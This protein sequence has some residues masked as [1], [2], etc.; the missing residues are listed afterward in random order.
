MPTVWSGRARL[1]RERRY[2][3]ELA[4]CRG[5][6]FVDEGSGVGCC[7]AANP[8]PVMVVV[9]L[10][11]DHESRP[12]LLVRASS[13]ACTSSELAEKHPANWAN[14]LG[15]TTWLLKLSSSEHQEAVCPAV[16]ANVDRI[17]SRT[18]RSTSAVSGS[19]PNPATMSIGS[20]TRVSILVGI[21]QALR[22]QQRQSE[23]ESEGQP[24]EL[25]P[26]RLSRQR[27]LARSN[28][29]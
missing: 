18:T 7:A 25:G 22:K 6:Q 4:L 1:P 16:S 5:A 19:G 28:R 27:S 26:M 13:T 21:G 8:G 15:H 17:R 10:M 3:V 12:Q 20:S 9:P 14:Q 24:G 2:G 23:R 11:P 29:G